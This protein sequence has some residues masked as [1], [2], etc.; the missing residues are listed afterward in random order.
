MHV[1]TKESIFIL[2][3]QKLFVEGTRKHEVVAE[4]L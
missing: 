4:I 1:T 2:A 3:L